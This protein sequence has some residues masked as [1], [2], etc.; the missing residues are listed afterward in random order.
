M[1][2]LLLFGGGSG[3]G[4][5]S[6]GYEIEGL[7]IR[8]LF[9]VSASQPFAADQDWHDL[10]AYLFGRDRIAIR[11][12]RSTEFDDVQTGTLD[13]TLDASNGDLDPRNGSSPHVDCLKPRRR[14]RLRAIHNDVV[15]PVFYGFSHGYPRNYNRPNTQ[16]LI[17]FKASEGFRVMGSADP[18]GGLFRLADPIYGRLGVGRLGGASADDQLSGLLIAALADAIGWPSD[19]R[20]ISDGLVTVFGD[21]ITSGR[22]DA[23]MGEASKAEGGELYISRDGKLTARDRLARY[24]EDRSIT[25]QATFVPSH[26]G[27][28]AA[29]NEPFSIEYDDTRYINRARYSGISDI[30]QMSEDTASI[31]EFGLNEDT[32]SYIAVN[33]S[34]VASLARLRVTDYAEPE[35]RVEQLVVNLHDPIQRDVAYPAVLGR[36]LFDRVDVDLASTYGAG[37]DSVPSVIQG[38][39]HDITKSTWI[40]TMRLG[41][42]K[43][44]Q[45]FTL[46][47]PTLG[48][49]GGV[50]VLAP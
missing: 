33:D 38:V 22:T 42:Y 48:Q 44:H 43:A 6:G 14:C 25:A 23:A 16:A 40:A 20:D 2:L 37:A 7:G 45:F 1:S 4:I 15:Y 11:R 21:D 30:V 27:V 18:T 19:L 5:P 32:Q 8:L 3:T 46:G 34:E 39:N 50:G 29:Y 9:E 47:D 41:P 49:L 10:S 12:G 35:D 28:N 31:G 13:T 36:E 24:T 26:D 17:P